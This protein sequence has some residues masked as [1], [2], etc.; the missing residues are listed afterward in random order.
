MYKFHCLLSF[1]VVVM[2]LIRT[3]SDIRQEQRNLH[4][5]TETWGQGVQRDNGEWYDG[6]NPEFEKL[7]TQRRKDVK[8]VSIL[9]SKSDLPTW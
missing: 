7:L 3:T 2:K 4:A 5:S 8:E 9:Q 1:F 6:I